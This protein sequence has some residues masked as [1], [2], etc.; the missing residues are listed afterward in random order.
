MTARKIRYMR[1]DLN[2]LHPR[3][4]LL[5]RL[6]AAGADGWELVFICN[7]N[8][9]VFQRPEQVADMTACAAKTP[10]AEH[11]KQVFESRAREADLT[12]GEVLGDGRSVTFTKG[13]VSY[14]DPANPC[15][16]WS[17][18]GRRPLWLKKE[19]AAGRRLQ[20]FID[21]KVD[22]VHFPDRP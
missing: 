4:T 19:L 1:L 13:P 7:R 21:E 14:R 5:S 9:A 8:M 10:D 3:E 22:N 11:L 18:L 15:N 6:N 2:S 17:G 20:E 16:T 12:L